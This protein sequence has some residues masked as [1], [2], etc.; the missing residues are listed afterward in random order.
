MAKKFELKVSHSGEKHMHARKCCGIFF[1]YYHAIGVMFS[2]DK[3]QAGFTMAHE[4][5]HFMD[6]Y[7]GKQNGRHFASDDYSG[8]AYAI[9]NTFRKNMNERQSSKYM[10][11]TCE[12]FARALE[13]YA[14][15]KTNM[16]GR[17]DPV[18]CYAKADVFTE[19]IIPMIDKWLETNNEL[20]KALPLVFRMGSDVV[21]GGLL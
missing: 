16:G 13:Q 6:N 11:R 2:G 18:D 4:W 7:A 15:H 5:A 10:N 17:Y 3:E 21:K 19:R 12:C 9:A 1:P 20:L 14:A 8:D